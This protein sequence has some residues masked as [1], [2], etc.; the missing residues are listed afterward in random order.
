MEDGSF[1]KLREAYLSYRIA[2]LGSVLN[3]VTLTVS[4]RNLFSIDNFFSYDPEV[5]AGGQSNRLRGVNFGT[6]PIPRTYTFT[7]KANF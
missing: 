1:T 4:G 3:N 5:N 7:L 2:Q 6:V